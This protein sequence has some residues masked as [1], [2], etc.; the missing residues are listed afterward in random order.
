MCE[1]HKAGSSH[2][3]RTT[4]MPVRTQQLDHLANGSNGPPA[5]ETMLAVTL[6]GD[7]VSACGERAEDHVTLQLYGG[8]DWLS[9]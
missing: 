5:A 8:R 2:L 9:T 3:Q 1:F 4:A 6:R 7:L